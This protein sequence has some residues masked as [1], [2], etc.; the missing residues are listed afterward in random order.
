MTRRYGRAPGGER[1]GGTI[2]LHDG[3]PSTRMGALGLDGLQA[4]MTG[5]GAPAAD[6]FRTDVQ[7]VL[8]LTWAPGEMV[9]RAHRSAP[10][11][12][13]LPPALAR[14]RARRLDGPP[15]APAWSPMERGVRQVKTAVR[16]AQARTR[17]ALDATLQQV[18]K[19][20]TAIDAQNWFRHCGYAL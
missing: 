11:A 2:P 1:R 3:A 19:T 8:G 15:D 12:P 14:R 10:K 9:V 18:M 6:G 5:E 20:V 7:P 17:L 16:A 13:G 4:V